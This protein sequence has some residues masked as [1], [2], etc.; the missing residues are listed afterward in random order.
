MDVLEGG[1]TDPGLPS[2]SQALK[3]QRNFSPVCIVIFIHSTCHPIKRV[4]NHKLRKPTILSIWVT[5]GQLGRGRTSKQDPL[6]TTLPIR[7]HPHFTTRPAL[8]NCQGLMLQCTHQL[9]RGRTS[10]QDPLLTTL[11]IRNHPHF[12]TRPAVHNCQ[13]LMLQCTHRFGPC[14]D[15]PQDYQGLCHPLK[16]D[17]NLP[18]FHRGPAQPEPSCQ[19]ILQRLS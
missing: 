16:S 6:L 13:G 17:N 12:T 4:D 7:N 18:H 1:P 19:H 3:E 14:V 9:G 2:S 5:G 11:P 8:H 15:L 10:K